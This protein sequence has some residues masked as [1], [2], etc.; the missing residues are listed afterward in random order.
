MLFEKFEAMAKFQAELA[1]QDVV[2]FGAITEEI[3]SATEAVVSGRKVILAGTNNYL[4]LSFDQRCISA[5]QEAAGK[6]GTGT[7]GSRLA[8]GTFIEH[9][10]LERELAAFY[11][12]NHAIIF[13]TGFA[14]T[15]GMCATL[16]GPGEVILLDADSHASIYA[17]VQ[18][19]GAEVIRFKHNDPEDLAKRLRRL[20]ERASQ[21]LIVAEGIYSMLGDTAPLQEIV[22][23]KREY[24]GWLFVDEAHSMGVL[25]DHGRGAT[26]AAGVESEVDFI[27]GTFSKSLGGTGGYCVSRHPEL[28]TIRY[29]IRSYIFT[30]SS[31]P[32]LVASTRKAL[33]ILQSEPELRHQLWDNAR[34]LFSGLQA[35]G[36]AVGPSASPVV[37]VTLEDRAQ[38][39]NCWNALMEAG[40]YANLVVPPASPSTNFLLRNSV[41][42]AHSSA[43]I[44]AIIAAYAGLVDAGLLGA[45]QGA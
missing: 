13:T 24:G 16:A 7:T 21:T 29:C 42:A 5:A 8:N 35:L 43:Q 39:I 3:L 33:Q 31:S 6:W 15:M 28:D 17:G 34:R 27:A 26:E 40:V 14:A 9:H 25:G 18:L 30:A 45:K 41:S 1:A 11:G 23:V 10:T 20:G 2:P 19:S 12:V 32:M 37:A 36:L 44:D 38:A 4:G 22:A